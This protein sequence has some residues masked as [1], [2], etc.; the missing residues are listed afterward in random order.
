LLIVLQGLDASGKD[1]PIKHVMS[2]LNPQ[3]VAVRSFKRPS[4]E[5]LEHDFLWRYQAAPP[6]RG[7]IGPLQPVALR[8]GARGPGSPGAAG[9]GE[10][11]SGCQKGDIWRRRYR[12]IN[13]WERYL[14]GNGIHVVK[15]M[16]N[17]SRRKQAERF[18]KRID[19]SEKN[20]KFAPS[21]V[22]E[23]AY[24][25][26]YQRAFT[27]M[28]SATSTPWAPWYV[29]PGD[30]KWFSHLATAA[31]VVQK[32]RAVNPD[33]PAADSAAAGQMA[34]VRAEL[35]AELTGRPAA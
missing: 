30:H 20:W 21:D 15:I 6:G 29:V 27:D 32:L 31:V 7:R 24:W 19:R 10:P 25:P 18:L 13:C 9:G 26:A 3:G 17:V 34:E 14:V 16:L 12:D 5:D 23:R 11:A 22:R 1:S 33:Y 35:M 4:R 28:L 8:G 2:G